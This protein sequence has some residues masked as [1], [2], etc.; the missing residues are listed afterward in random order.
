MFG[1][2]SAPIVDFYRGRP[3]FRRIDGNLPPDV[4]T[5]S[6]RAAIREASMVTAPVKLTPGAAL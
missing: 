6:M 1:L 2:Q 5:E 3:T 4:V